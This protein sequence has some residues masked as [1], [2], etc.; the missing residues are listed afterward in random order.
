MRR[1]NAI[2]TCSGAS[3]AL[4]NPLGH[5]LLNLRVT[6]N[7]VQ[8]KTFRVGENT[9]P[10]L[11]LCELSSAQDHGSL[12]NPRTCQCCSTFS[13]SQRDSVSHLFRLSFSKPHSL[14]GPSSTCSTYNAGDS[15][16]NQE[17]KSAV[18]FHCTRNMLPV[19]VNFSLL[20]HFSSLCRTFKGK[21]KQNGTKQKHNHGFTTMQITIYLV[22][23]YEISYASYSLCS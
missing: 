11:S 3:S 13:Q 15:C 2:L 4:P 12:Y 19:P 5:K 17:K 1:R 10:C 6:K 21:T 8:G 23:A 14:P 16:L 18:S 20:D 22:D 7:I 9:C